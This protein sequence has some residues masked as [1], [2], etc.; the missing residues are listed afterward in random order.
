MDTLFL[1]LPGTQAVEDVLAGLMDRLRPGQTVVDLSTM[2][3][4][5]TVGIAGALAARG[6]GFLDAPVSGMEAR[7]IDGPLTVMC[8]G[9]PEVFGR[10]APLRGQIGS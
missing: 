8:G 1:C 3:Y 6:V 9:A 4:Q 7:A 10:T 2:G 5:A